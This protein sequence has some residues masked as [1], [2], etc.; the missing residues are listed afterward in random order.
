MQYAIR[1]FAK[2]YLLNYSNKLYFARILV[3]YYSNIYA[4]SIDYSNEML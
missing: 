1:I 4:D 2:N 3:E